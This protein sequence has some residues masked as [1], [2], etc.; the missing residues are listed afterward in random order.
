MS[1]PVGGKIVVIDDEME[2]AMPLIEALSRKGYS[3]N[4]FS[5]DDS[6]LPAEPSAD[7]RVVFLDI[8]LVGTKA[9]DPKS[10]TSKAASV[11]ERLVA[12]ETKYIL[13]AW[14]KH[15]DVIDSLTEYLK[16]ANICPIIDVIDLDKSDCFTEDKHG[17]DFDVAF[18]ERKIDEKL[19]DLGM[20]KFFIIWENLVSKSSSKIFNDFTSLLPNGTSWDEEM[21]KIMYD[22]AKSYSGE[23]LVTTDLNAIAKSGLL[24][25][26]NIFTETLERA[27]KESDFSSSGLRNTGGGIAEE[28]KAEINSRLLF[29]STIGEVRPGNIYRRNISKVDLSSALKE[30]VQQGKEGLFIAEGVIPILIEMSPACD[31]SQNKWETHRLLEGILCPVGSSEDVKKQLEK[32][33]KT[34]DNLYPNKPPYLFFKWNG[35]IYRLVFNRRRL[36]SLDIGKLEKLTPLFTINMSYLADIQHSIASHVSRPGT[37]SLT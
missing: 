7:V 23:Q 3:V 27:I 25:F 35:H 10:M 16:T 9:T 11:L 28:I 13:V 32:Q 34:G 36:I 26:N 29:F 22:L 5:G 31:Y 30:Y 12:K 18:I 17:K 6:K 24:T 14:T 33:A 37:I 2:E 19:Q 4:Y 20:F 1:L 21:S 8:E 15:S